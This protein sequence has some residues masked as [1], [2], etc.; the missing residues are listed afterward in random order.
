MA[1]DSQTLPRSYAVLTRTNG[2]ELH[3]FDASRAWY[4]LALLAACITFWTVIA[5]VAL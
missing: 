1:E 2:H 5:L 4:S 3:A